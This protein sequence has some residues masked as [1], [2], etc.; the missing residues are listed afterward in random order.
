[1]CRWALECDEE[2][3]RLVRLVVGWLAE[4]VGVLWTGRF[5]PGW[6]SYGS[7]DLAHAEDITPYDRSWMLPW[8]RKA[9]LV[10]NSLTFT[11]RL[12]GLVYSFSL[13]QVYTNARQ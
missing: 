6:T 10:A 7:E 13:Y 3:G 2:S 9:T 12:Q 11:R 4:P 8:M 5:M 1:M